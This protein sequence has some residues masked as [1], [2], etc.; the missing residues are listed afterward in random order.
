MNNLRSHFFL[1]LFFCSAERFASKN[2]DRELLYFMWPSEPKKP[3]MKERLFAGGFRIGALCLVL[4]LTACGGG[5]GSDNSNSDPPANNSNF[6]PASVSGDILAL[7][8]SGENDRQITFSDASNWQENDNSAVGTY[9]YQ[10]NQDG[11]TAVLTLN[12]SGASQTITFNFSSTTGGNFAYTAGRNGSGTFTL[13]QNQ[14]PGP[15]P[16]IDPPPGGKAPASLGGKTMLGTRTFTSTGPVGQTHTYTFTANTFHDADPPEQSDGNYVYQPNG[17]SAS[18]QLNYTKP[19]TF[20]GDTHD[21]QMRFD[22]PTSGVFTST[23]TR[24]DGTMI[25]INGNFEFQ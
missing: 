3:R 9:S 20:A 21:L 22:T 4:M 17:D 15:P 1:P 16:P 13:T 2:L 23:Y 24:D 10:A 7:S 5:G 6:A 18:L 12:Q 25:Q 19:A 14:N 11:R 8:V